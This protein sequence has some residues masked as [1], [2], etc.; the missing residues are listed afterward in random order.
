[1]QFSG[2]VPA[3]KR[4]AAGKLASAA[5]KSVREYVEKFRAGLPSTMLNSS[6]YAFNVF[7]VPRVA[8]RKQMADA[9]VEFIRVD[10]ASPEELE[11][12]S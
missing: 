6:R 4:K 8:N 2:V 12:R 3:E 11:R 1:M 7:L 5:A 10:E 9:A